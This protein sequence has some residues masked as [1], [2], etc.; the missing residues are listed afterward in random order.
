MRSGLWAIAFVLSTHSSMAL[1]DK[2]NFII[3]CITLGLLLLDVV[4][5]FIKL[6]GGK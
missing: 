6:S 5:Y 4:E 2:A 3:F 1:T